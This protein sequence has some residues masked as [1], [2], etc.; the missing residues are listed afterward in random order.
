MKILEPYKQ[1]NFQLKDVWILRI[2]HKWMVIVNP[3]VEA[4]CLEVYL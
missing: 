1:Y 4:Q 3:F 2:N